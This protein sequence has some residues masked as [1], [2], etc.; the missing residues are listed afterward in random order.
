MKSTIWFI[1][2]EAEKYLKN[3]SN[4]SAFKKAYLSVPQ[5]IFGLQSYDRLISAYLLPMVSAFN[6]S[7]PPLA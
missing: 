1:I 6:D 5:T 4:S 7:E 3:I 2:E